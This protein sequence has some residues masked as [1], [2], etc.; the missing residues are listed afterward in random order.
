MQC[1]K[2]GWG[3]LE[4]IKTHKHTPTETTQKVDGIETQPQ[5]IGWVV[6][7]YPCTGFMQSRGPIADQ[8]CK[9]WKENADVSLRKSASCKEPSVS[10][11]RVRN[12]ALTVNPP[13]PYLCGKHCSGNVHRSC[14]AKWPQ[15]VQ[16]CSRNS[17][18]SRC[19]H[20]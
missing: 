6:K 2:N 1:I 15:R 8:S 14:S 20:W 4:H 5:G 3:L 7:D 12:Q 16:S 11:H 10:H 19:C 17:A 9:C 18:R 13:I